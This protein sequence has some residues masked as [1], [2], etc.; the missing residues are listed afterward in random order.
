MNRLVALLLLLM[1]LPLSACITDPVTGKSSFGID[2]SEEAEIEM[3]LGY[4]P[5][6]RSQYEG[7]Y[8]DAALNAYCGKIVLGMARNSHRPDLP[9]TF[10][11]LNSS[12]V[13]AFAL[14]GGTVCI[15]RGLLWQ[16][17]SEAEFAGVMGHEIGHVSHRHSVKQQSNQTIYQVLVAAA[18]VAV[19]VSDAEYG[20]EIVAAGAIGGQLLLLSYSRDQES[21]SDNRGVEYAYDAGY[22]PRE[23][24]GVFEL[25]KELK[26][27]SGGSAPPVWLS[28]HPLDDDR[29]LE[30]YAEVDEK[31]P[32]VAKSNG[33]GLVKTTPEWERLMAK[34]RQDQKVYNDYDRAADAF[35]EAVKSNNAGALRQVLATMQQCS[36]RLPSHAIFVSGEGVVHYQ[37]R[38][39]STAKARFKKAISM[40]GDL[41]EPHYYLS[42]IEMSEGN[43]SSAIRSA[44]AAERLW[45]HHPGPYFVEAR[46]H[47]RIGNTKE[48]VPDYQAVLQLAPADSA[49]YKF[50]ADR[51][52]ALGY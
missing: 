6:F 25:F 52:K 20:E 28:T 22:D 19:E 46:S 43:S 17:D 15:T 32:A 31:Y 40:Q 3:G 44:Q 12:Q 1:L 34:L 14:P 13:N 41:F 7:A 39:W 9:W 2:M 10:T 30:V 8:P 42:L 26:A 16:L 51:L 37:M 29:I 18:A 49:E 47:D 36:R 50:S 23:L 35:A 24:A 33:K 45:P 21:E 11:I 38:Q 4:A 48:A 5:S 27:E